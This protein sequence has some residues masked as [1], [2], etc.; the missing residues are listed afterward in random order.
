MKPATPDR[1]APGACWPADLVALAERLDRWTSMVRQLSGD[2]TPVLH[3][4]Q[5]RWEAMLRELTG[6]RALPLDCRQHLTADTVPAGWEGADD[7][8]PPRGCRRERQAR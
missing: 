5:S 1:S 8:P 4:Q 7:E 3:P 2:Q 6:E